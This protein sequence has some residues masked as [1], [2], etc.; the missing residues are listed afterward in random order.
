MSFWLIKYIYLM[1]KKMNKV[2]WW[3]GLTQLWS[4]SS[5]ENGRLISEHRGRSDSVWK[6]G[7][8]C[9][10]DDR[11][12]MTTG[13]AVKTCVWTIG[14]GRLCFS[15][16]KSNL[17]KSHLGRSPEKAKHLINTTWFSS[18]NKEAWE[19]LHLSSELIS[20]F[21]KFSGFCQI[22]IN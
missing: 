2:H 16:W 20:I 12:G 1:W 14:H 6:A 21:S 8:H 9:K 11:P 7:T 18:T 3:T 4:F 22:N 17:A 13:L 10:I 15:Q 5:D 19:N